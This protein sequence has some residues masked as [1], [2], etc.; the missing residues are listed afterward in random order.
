MSVTLDPSDQ[1]PGDIL[2]NN[3]RFNS[4]LDMMVRSQNF[5]TK[6]YGRDLSG[7]AWYDDDSDGLIDTAE[8]FVKDIPVKLYRTSLDDENYKNELV[9]ESLTG[10]KFVDDSGNSLIKTDANGKYLFSNLA[11]GEYIAEFVV[12]DQVVQK[13]FSVTEPL[14]GDDPTL[15][16]KADQDTFKTDEY[17]QPKLSDLATDKNLTNATHHVTDV[18]IGLIRLSSIRLFKYEAGSAVDADS[19]GSLSDTEKSTGTPLASATFDLYKG[20]DQTEKIGTAT[21]D[22][23]G[24]LNFTGLALGD[25]NLVETKAPKGYELIK[26]P[27][28]VTLAEANQTVMVYQDN[29]KTT[30]LPHAGGNGPMV[31]LL[32]IAS[33]LGLAGLGALYHYYRQPRKKGA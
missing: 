30:E 10:E 22:A 2:V 6:V 12:G 21:T 8:P 3:V 4:H 5:E 26:T 18:N 20:N 24:Y 14:V 13:K 7:V 28:K 16:S 1:K 19:D 23:N 32:G 11:E 9:K 25:Y 33:A 15:N 29:E 31:W 27:I 17:T